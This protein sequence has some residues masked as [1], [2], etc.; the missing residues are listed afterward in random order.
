M[1]VI[2]RRHRPRPALAG[3][4]GLLLGEGGALDQARELAPSLAEVLDLA[5][6]G[7]GGVRDGSLTHARAHPQTSARGWERAWERGWERT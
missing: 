6:W 5:W 4:A 1:P 2:A 7:G 3:E